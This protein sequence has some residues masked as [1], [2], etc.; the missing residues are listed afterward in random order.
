M[1]AENS[2]QRVGVEIVRRAIEAPIK[3]IA[4]NAAADALHIAITAASGIDYLLTWNCRHL[5]SAVMR[6]RIEQRCI[7][8][9]FR[10]PTICTPEE[11]IGDSAHE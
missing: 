10:P 3:Q 7:E 5:A 9:G 6:D 1:Q 8:R 4:E 11:P 2:G